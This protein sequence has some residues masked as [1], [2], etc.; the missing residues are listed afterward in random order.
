V[1]CECEH[2]VVFLRGRVQSYYH[3]Q[4]AQE[5]V[6]KIDGVAQVVNEVEVVD[7]LRSR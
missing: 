3:K 1:S 2:G 5:A 4:L 6:G 7:L